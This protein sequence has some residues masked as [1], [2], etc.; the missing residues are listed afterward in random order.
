MTVP[1]TSRVQ[2]VTP[3]EHMDKCSLSFDHVLLPTAQVHHCLV[4]H[5]I[6]TEA[7]STRVAPPLRVPRETAQSMRP[8]TVGITEIGS[9]QGMDTV[10]TLF[11]TLG[12]AKK[13]G[14]K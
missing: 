3:Y 5:C 7:P 8:R 2:S 1:Y 10:G 12:T 4:T 6:L 11:C 14:Q 9:W 13:G